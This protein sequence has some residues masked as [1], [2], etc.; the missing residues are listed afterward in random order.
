MGN[1]TGKKSKVYP[2]K[3]IVESSGLNNLFERARRNAVSLS[4]EYIVCG[5]GRTMVFTVQDQI[6][7][8]G[9]P[10]LCKICIQNGS[11]NLM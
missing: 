1:C 5:C 7:M 2:G 6:R 10:L 11:L 4:D 3:K 9:R 8:V